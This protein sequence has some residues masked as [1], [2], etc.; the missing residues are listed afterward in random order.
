M[1][2]LDYVFFSSVINKDYIFHLYEIFKSYTK[3]P[4][5]E[6]TRK[7]INQLTGHLQ[8]DIYF[9]TLK[10]SYFNFAREEFYKPVVS[11]ETNKDLVK[12]KKVVPFDIKKI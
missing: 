6:I 12:I 11:I 4:P 7:K 9:S 5:K 10:Y 1:E 3:T 2:I 8:T